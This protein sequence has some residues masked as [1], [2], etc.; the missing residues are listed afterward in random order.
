[1]RY[2]SLPL[3]TAAAVGKLHSPAFSI[4]T[5]KVSMAVLASARLVAEV[6]SR[7]TSW[8]ASVICEQGK[9]QFLPVQQHSDR[10]APYTARSW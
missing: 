8:L 1:M 3:T 6:T 10:C 5:S 9:E 2:I 7:S 4:S